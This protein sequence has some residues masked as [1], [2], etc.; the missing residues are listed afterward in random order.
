MAVR[1]KGIECGSVTEVFGL[2]QWED[3]QSFHDEMSKDV[4]KYKGQ[5]QKSVK[6]QGGA[7][8]AIA[9]GAAILLASPFAAGILFKSTAFAL[10]M[11]T[12]LSGVFTYKRS[13]IQR[14]KKSFTL[15]G[16]MALK[17][18]AQEE[19]RARLN[20]K[21][22]QYFAEE[23]EEKIED[24]SFIDKEQEDVVVHEIA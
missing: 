11:T 5:R 23:K 13:K 24:A 16:L 14:R 1:Y 6:K 17:E 10:G 21:R 3:L 22:Q 9:I 2:M 18:G 20:G 12:F 8:C 4:E 19:I 15:L 7:K